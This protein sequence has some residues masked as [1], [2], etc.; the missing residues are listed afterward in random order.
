MEHPPKQLRCGFDA[1]LCRVL[2]TD[3]FTLFTKYTEISPT[4]AP[5]LNPQPEMPQGKAA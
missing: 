4:D 2:R 3:S 5:V 1:S